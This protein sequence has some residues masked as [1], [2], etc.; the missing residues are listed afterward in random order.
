MIKIE[1]TTGMKM[2]TEY[3]VT[4]A[5][6]MPTNQVSAFVIAH[7]GV[8]LNTTMMICCIRKG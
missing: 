3:P 6:A 4:C 2:K 5:Y 1:G 7:H 8:I